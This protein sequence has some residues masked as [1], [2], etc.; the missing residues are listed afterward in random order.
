MP[1]TSGNLRVG[2]ATPCL[3]RGH[4]A[5]ARTP[6]CWQWLLANVSLRNRRLRSFAYRGTDSTAS[7]G[8][9]SLR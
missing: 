6:D 7:D 4:L 8:T 3:R 2:E 1:R 9:G 5:A